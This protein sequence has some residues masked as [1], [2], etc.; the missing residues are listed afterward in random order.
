MKIGILDIGTNKISCFIV[1]IA[2]DK[3]PPVA[4]IGSKINTFLSVNIL[5]F[6]TSQISFNI[7]H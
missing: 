1:N 2:K 7:M 5:L 6:S 4:S 3:E